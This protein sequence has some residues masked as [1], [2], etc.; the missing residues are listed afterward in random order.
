MSTSL[1]ECTSSCQKT[2]PWFTR[3]ANTT[4][5]LVMVIASGPSSLQLG[6]NLACKYFTDLSLES[7]VGWS[8]QSSSF[9]LS[10][11]DNN[12]FQWW[13]LMFWLKDESETWQV[14][15]GQKK[16]L[17]G[18]SNRIPVGGKA[19]ADLAESH[20]G[21]F[22]LNLF[23]KSQNWIKT[24]NSSLYHVLSVCL[25]N[26]PNQPEL[27][28]CAQV[29]GARMQTQSLSHI[30]H[31]PTKQYL[32]NLAFWESRIFFVLITTTLKKHKSYKMDSSY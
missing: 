9:Q 2:W 30:T 3:N 13:W 24:Q 20:K 21:A 16:A 11:I 27:S 29:P 8:L 15:Y 18:P 22:L 4:L 1:K 7:R 26:G 12:N 23:H 17:Y 19:D 25:L 6:M 5:A 10:S 31:F 14:T 28:I 32:G